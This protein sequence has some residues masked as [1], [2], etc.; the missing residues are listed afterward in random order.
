MGRDGDVST[1][2]DMLLSSD[3]TLDDLPVIAIV[4]MGGMG[5]TTLAQ[6]VYNNEKVVKH[7]GDQRMWICVSDDFIVP[8]LLSQMV[9]SL[10]GDKSD[11]DNIE[12]IVRK[13]AEKLNG[14]KYLL[15]LD[16]VWNENPDKWECMR[17]SLLRIGGS[18]GSK[19]IAI[20]RSMHVVSTMRTSPSFTHHLN[21]LSENESWTMFQKRAFAN[22]GPTETPN[23][24]AI[25]RKMV[26]KYKGVPLAIKSLGDFNI[27]KDELI[28]LWMAQGYLQP[29]SGSNLEMEDVGNDY[30]NILL[31]N[32]LFQDVKLDDYNN[33]TSCKMHDLVHDLALDVSEGTCLG[34]TSIAS[35]ANH[36]SEF[37]K[38]PKEN[39]GKLRTLL[40][41]GNLPKNIADVKFIRALSFEQYY[42]KELPD[43][44]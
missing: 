2:I 17:N 13:L 11:I 22:G 36:H 7:F 24:V 28:Q 32:S 27:Q 9:Q 44:I 14:K 5:K 41:T 26:E 25:G 4:G 30:F 31:H 35:E 29:S 43:S 33:I 1:V 23:L 37:H 40:L 16:D 8:K 38:I 10:T 18:K 6:L 34:L 3:N 12:G 42:V 15:V 21:Q 19:I 39:V 20:T